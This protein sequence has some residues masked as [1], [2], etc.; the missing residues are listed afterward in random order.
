MRVTE[1]HFLAE[2]FHDVCNIEFALFLRNPGIEHDVKEDVTELLLDILVGLFEYGIAQ[3]VR[4][5]N[6]HRPQ[7][8]HG[9]GPVPRTFFTQPVHNVEYTT[10][11]REL[12]FVRMCHDTWL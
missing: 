1:N 7:G 4:L 3:F 6:G 9:L 11:L 5:L 10:E 8:L 2:P 12:F